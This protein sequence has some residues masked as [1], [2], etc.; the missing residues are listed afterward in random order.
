MALIVSALAG[1]GVYCLASSLIEG[2]A[3]NARITTGIS[4]HITSSSVLWL[5]RDGVGLAPRRN[6]TIANSSKARTKMLIRTQ[7]VRSQ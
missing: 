6:L 1:A 3:I 2:I 7:S 5:L 4:V